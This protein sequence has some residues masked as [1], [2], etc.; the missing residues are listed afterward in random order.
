MT[1]EMLYSTYGDRI[2]RLINNL[3]P[4][5]LYVSI[6][7]VHQVGGCDQL[8]NYQEH[9][10]RRSDIRYIPINS[11][12]VTKSR[13]VAIENS[14]AD[15]VLFCDDDVVYEDDFY[16]KVI[17]SYKENSGVDFITFSYNRGLTQPVKFSKRKTKHDL[18]S[19]LSV[20]T[21][22]ISCLRSS[23]LN[24]RC[25]FPED[26]GTGQKLF[27]CDEPVFLASL[28]RAGCRGIYVPLNIC[29]HP[30]ESSGA[31]FKSYYA[32]ESRYEC[33]KRVFGL[34]MGRVLFFCFVF[35]RLKDFGG[36]VRV[37]K[38]IFRKV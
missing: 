36:G 8:M 9:F 34:F 19:I 35:Y 17:L 7:I 30:D 24:A 26:M 16:K 33:F 18:F 31:D 22:E 20:G 3:P 23:L 15:I 29:D 32:I 6:T 38:Y 1:L 10:K 12:G 11:V 4:Q 27:L 37:L 28:I 14:H 5:S 13:N 25:F 21:I 2:F